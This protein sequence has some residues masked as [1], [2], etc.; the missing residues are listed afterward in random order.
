MVLAGLKILWQTVLI[1]KSCNSLNLICSCHNHV[2]LTSTVFNFH[3]IAGPKHLLQRQKQLPLYF[4]VEETE[5]LKS[6]VTHQMWHSSKWQRWAETKGAWLL[7]WA[8]SLHYTA[9]RK[10]WDSFVPPWLAAWRSL[11]PCLISILRIPCFLLGASS[12]L[13]ADA[14][15]DGD[16]RCPCT[17]PPPPRTSF[18]SRWTWQF[19]PI[20]PK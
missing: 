6:E 10:S 15:R 19:L 4:T 14:D 8:L 1:S 7:H 13:D 16:K 20:V 3:H 5:S 11:L 18:F 12:V 17:A 2:V 9:F